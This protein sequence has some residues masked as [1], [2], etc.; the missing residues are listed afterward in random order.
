MQSATGLPI[1]TTT[2]PPAGRAA[3]RGVLLA[4]LALLLAGCGEGPR[5]EKMPERQ[6]SAGG[7]MRAE[8]MDVPAS[9]AR[10]EYRP[11]P[12]LAWVDE[13]R[14]ALADG[15]AGK[16]VYVDVGS[17]EEQRFARRGMGPGEVVLPFALL[18]RE[19]DG[20]LVAD[21]TAMRV[22]RFGADG[23]ARETAPLPGRPLALLG[24]S[25]GTVRAAWIDMET[26]QPAVGDVDLAGGEPRLR[27]RPYAASDRVAA[28]ARGM[29]GPSPFVPLAMDAGGRVYV[30][31]GTTYEVFRFD[32][33]EAEG[34]V[35]ATLGRP[36]VRSERMEDEEFA[37]FERNLS[38]VL[39][40]GGTQAMAQRDAILARYRAQPKPFFRMGSLSVD[41]EGRLWVVTTRTTADAT[42]VDVFSPA[43][44][45]LGTL[46]LRGRVRVLAPRLPYLAVLREETWGDGEE[47]VDV[48]RI[49][50]HAAD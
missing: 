32:P 20:V 2:R 31:G 17:G 38:Q 46:A 23:R 3:L 50:E 45:F 8:R 15:D 13:K 29:A 6:P 1:S 12:A 10:L 24:W 42:E 22:T 21:A 25:G 26:N 41:Q 19:P 7:A 43:G 16:I 40:A 18:S 49:T 4:A 48:Y 5:R 35:A 33:G 27:L 9:L 28:S 34:R 36:E 14:L 39:A 47:G 37:A 11:A 30:G 44:A